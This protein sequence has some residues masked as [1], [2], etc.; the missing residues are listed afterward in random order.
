MKETVVS[1]IALLSQYS[2][3]MG[4][5]P[6]GRWLATRVLTLTASF[7]TFLMFVYFCVDITAEM[8]AGPPEIP[9]KNFGDVIEH[10]YTVVVDSLWRLDMLAGSEP[11][12]APHRIAKSYTER[13]SDYLAMEAIMS[14]RKKLY[15]STMSNAVTSPAGKQY[16]G[17]LI[18]LNMDES[19]YHISTLP[20]LKGSEFLPLFNY[21]ILKEHEHGII[22]RL[23]HKYHPQMFTLE[24]FSMEEPQP[25]GANNV[26]FPFIWLA[27][28]I[29]VSFAIA[30]AELIKR[31]F[32]GKITSSVI[33]V[34]HQNEMLPGHSQTVDKMPEI[35]AS[36]DMESIRVHDL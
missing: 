2:L 26:M 32:F 4:S 8:T 28:G 12:S 36:P 1:N 7:I 15:F 11:G 24:Q 18:S 14:D 33:E 34:K 6:N 22:K 16:A 17:Q 13:K 31:K 29:C 3:Q 35:P 30:L 27:F 23:Y 10:G 19:Y 9:I 25:L 5:H 20:L 21:Y